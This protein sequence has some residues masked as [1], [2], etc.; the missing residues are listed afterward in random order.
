MNGWYHQTGGGRG[1][2]GGGGTRL[3]FF[4]LPLFLAPATPPRLRQLRSLCKFQFRIPE[5]RS[6]CSCALLILW[7]YIHLFKQKVVPSSTS[8]LVFSQNRRYSNLE[9][10][11]CNNIDLCRSIGGHVESQR[12]KKL[13][14]CM[15]SLA[16]NSRLGEAYRTKTKVF[17]SWPSSDRGCVT[18]D[19]RSAHA[20]SI[21]PSVDTA[22]KWVRMLRW[23]VIQ[24]WID[25]ECSTSIAKFT[26]VTTIFFLLNKI[27][28]GASSKEPFLKAAT[29]AILNWAYPR[30]MRTS[31]WNFKKAAI[32]PSKIAHA[33]RACAV[34]LPLC[35]LGLA[36][37]T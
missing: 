35:P 7:Q 27:C 11:Y 29:L 20:L 12:N 21:W 14:L 25:Y 36:S 19:V 2:G 15:E 24:S 28:D 4:L 3:L 26:P 17:N 1:G 32:L 13:W 9:F 31:N 34:I 30:E 23:F 22:A 6:T 33:W 8:Y 10:N 37:V 18:S 5:F 16:L